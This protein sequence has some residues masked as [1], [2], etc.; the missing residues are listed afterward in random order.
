M[1]GND[2]RREPLEE[3]A[4]PFPDGIDKVQSRLLAGDFSRV[5]RIRLLHPR[6]AIEDLCVRHRHA[7]GLSGRA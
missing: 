7:L 1:I 3:R 6:Q 5:K 4:E 2:Y